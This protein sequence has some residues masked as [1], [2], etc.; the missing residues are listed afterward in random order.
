MYS[1]KKLD[2]CL[3]VELEGNFG[4]ETILQVLER[5]DESS[6]ETPC[7]NEMWMV[8]G[9]T[10]HL[11]LRDVLTVVEGIKSTCSKES[12]ISPEICQKK[13]A[14]VVCQQDF[15]FSILELLSEGI[16]RL[17][18][19]GCRVFNSH[20]AASEWLGIGSYGNEVDSEEHGA[21]NL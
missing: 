19:F 12:C 18:P 6:F 1:L 3:I 9:H 11:R 8:G 20:E 2:D 15:T 10:A 4:V 7:H 16:S 17:C 21:T 13:M 5:R 14:F